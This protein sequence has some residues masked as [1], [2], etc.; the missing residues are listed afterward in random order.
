MKISNQKSHLAVKNGVGLLL[1]LGWVFWLIVM[2]MVSINSLTF[3]PPE[4]KTFLNNGNF[5]NVFI[6]LIFFVLSTIVILNGF[7]G[8]IWK[9]MNPG[10]IGV[11]G[12]G[13]E[14]KA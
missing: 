1:L 6:K 11:K 5:S 7:R 12:K 9:K 2:L 8:V 13:G 14:A 4:V 3:L 10:I